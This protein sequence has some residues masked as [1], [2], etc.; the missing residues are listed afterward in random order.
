MPT[1]PLAQALMP[2]GDPFEGMSP[3]DAF[4]LRRELAGRYVSPEQA[5]QNLRT[6]GKDVL[7]VTPGPGNVMSAQDAYDSAGEAYNQFSQGNLGKG[8]LATA[9]AG[10][11]GASAVFGVPFGRM[12]KGVAA[13][14]PRTMNIFAGP[15][16]KT[17]DQA[18]LAKAQE[19]AQ[20]GASRDDIWSQTGW[21]S[22]PDG[23]WRFEIDDSMAGLKLGAAQQFDDMPMSPDW[24]KAD[25][26]MKGNAGDMFNHP[27]L[28]SAYGDDIGGRHVMA[29][30]PGKEGF[31]SDE[32][33]MVGIGGPDAEALRGPALHELQHA[34]QKREGF[35]GGANP[36]DPNYP[37][38]PG[39]I[40]ARNV[41]IRRNMRPEERRANAPWTTQDIPHDQIVRPR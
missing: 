16:A 36:T 37:M 24:W 2:Q 30:T 1:S 13:D 5:S 35:A 12:A 27:E 15:A 7:S 25:A 10:L 11:S 3:V 28:F 4:K 23:K 41:D 32:F 14:A 29:R 21:F 39:E 9:L 17:A 33:N 8:A 38:M 20:A 34:I 6:T 18:A 31:Q 22:G 19:M 40:E 26:T